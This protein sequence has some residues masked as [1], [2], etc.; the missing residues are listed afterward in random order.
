MTHPSTQRAL[1]TLAND[2]STTAYLQ[3]LAAQNSYQKYDRDYEMTRESVL[4]RRLLSFARYKAEV[5]AKVR[6]EMAMGWAAYIGSWA[7]NIAIVFLISRTL[8]LGAYEAGK[9]AG[10]EQSAVAVS[11]AQVEKLKTEKER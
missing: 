4:R 7:L 11:S 3:Q 5:R 8:I 2:S 6:R 9:T 1:N 10:I